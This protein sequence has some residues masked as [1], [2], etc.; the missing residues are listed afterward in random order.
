MARMSKDKHLTTWK[1]AKECRK[2]RRRER[3]KGVIFNLFFFFFPLLC[4][5]GYAWISGLEGCCAVSF[6]W[7]N[8]ASIKAT[9]THTQRHA[10]S[11]CNH[12][13]HRLAWFFYGL[14]SLYI[15]SCERRMRVVVWT[16][17]TLHLVRFSD[18]QVYCTWGGSDRC[19][20]KDNRLLHK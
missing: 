11:S 17:L 4:I 7:V 13:I 14:Y 12:E 10:Q 1:P 15:N 5:L 19:T 2:R 8:V 6:H 16:S 3:K 20:Q 18:A 9:F